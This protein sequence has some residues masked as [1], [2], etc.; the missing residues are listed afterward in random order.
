MTDKIKFTVEF[1]V[2]PTWVADGFF[3][4]KNTALMMLAKELGW[5]DIGSELDARM[6]KFPNAEKVAKLMGYASVE[7]MRADNPHA[8]EDHEW[9]NS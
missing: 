9:A 8:V 6:V 2:D 3:L 4:D 1:A 5:A 7:K